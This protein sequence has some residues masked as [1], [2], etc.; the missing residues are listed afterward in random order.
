MACPIKKYPIN[1]PVTIEQMNII[2]PQF[3]IKPLLNELS[4]VQS[5]GN[6]KSHAGAERKSKGIGRYSCLNISGTLAP[7]TGFIFA[8]RHAMTHIS[9]NIIV[10][11]TVL[12]NILFIL[13]NILITV[14]MTFRRSSDDKVDFVVRPNYR[15]KLSPIALNT[16]PS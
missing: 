5:I 4:K 9:P 13:K 8:A 16:L 7:Q 6:V 1:C 11:T 2:L 10:N 3:N 15:L 14:E 12:G